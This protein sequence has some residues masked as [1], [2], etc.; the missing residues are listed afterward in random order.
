MRPSVID[1]ER[2]QPPAKA[3]QAVVSLLETAA[4]QHIAATRLW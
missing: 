4:R 3:Q 2:R 1:R